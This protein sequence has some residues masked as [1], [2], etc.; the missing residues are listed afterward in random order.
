MEGRP[1]HTLLAQI[2][3]ADSVFAQAVE[4]GAEACICRARLNRTPGNTSEEW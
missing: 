4:A 1:E 3:V 2:F